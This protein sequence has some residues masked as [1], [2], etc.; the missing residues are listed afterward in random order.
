L[1]DNILILMK[2]DSVR[3]RVA[4]ITIVL[5]LV[6]I[7]GAQFWAS[8]M[9]QQEN[10]IKDALKPTI[11]EGIGKKPT[12]VTKGQQWKDQTLKTT[13]EGDDQTVRVVQVATSC[14]TTPRQQENLRMLGLH[15]C[16]TV[17]IGV[18]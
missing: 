17:H 3:F 5:F 4:V 8:K 13:G 6:G 1:F 14:M 15:P 11:K 9:M 2:G 16:S 7:G 10:P 18:R 12:L